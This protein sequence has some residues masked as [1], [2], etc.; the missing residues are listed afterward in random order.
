VYLDRYRSEPFVRVVATSS[1]SYRYPE[2]KLLC[3]S[4]FCDIGFALDERA[5]RVVLIAALDNL[6]KG[7]AGGA[8]QSVNVA[9]GL[10]E[11]AGLEFPGLH[12]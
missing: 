6:V 9:V 1:G 10:A 3:G 7:A 8:V 12:P 4:N 2:P 11:T 5:D